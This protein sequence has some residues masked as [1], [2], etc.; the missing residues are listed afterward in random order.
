[1]WMSCYYCYMPNNCYCTFG[2]WYV[3]I[4]VDIWFTWH[5]YV[6]YLTLI[7]YAWHLIPDTWYLTSVLNMFY[8]IPDLWHL[9]SDTGTWHIITWHLIPDIWYM[10]LDDWHAITHLTC[11]H[12]VLVHLTWYCDTWLD[13]ITPDACITLHIRDYH[14]YGELAWLLYCYQTSGSPEPLYS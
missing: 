7:C 13:T 4:R 10:T 5:R 14:F 6:N 11:F 9:I 12:I 1:M 2:T 3:A 8:L